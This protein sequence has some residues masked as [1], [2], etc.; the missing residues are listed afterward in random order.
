MTLKKGAAC[1]L[2]KLTANFKLFL[3]STVLLET[4]L[5][6]LFQLNSG[7]SGICR[8]KQQWLLL[9]S[10]KQKNITLMTRN[11]VFSWFVPESPIQKGRL[12]FRHKNL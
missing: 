6:E 8:A 4:V 9:R 7:F 10:K 5:R 3:N 11:I 1:N 2:E 12:V